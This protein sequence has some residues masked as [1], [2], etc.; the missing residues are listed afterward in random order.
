MQVFLFFLRF[1][2][3]FEATLKSCRVHDYVIS[4][5]AALDIFFLPFHSLQSPHFT[6]S[7]VVESSDIHGKNTR[8]SV[9]LDYVDSIVD[10]T[11]YQAVC[12]GTDQE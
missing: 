3:F 4:K 5:V 1:F 2:G 10:Y 9:D 7:S 11:R 12:E 8:T 6:L